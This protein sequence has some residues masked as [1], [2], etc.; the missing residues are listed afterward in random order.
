M[1]CKNDLKIETNRVLEELIPTLCLFMQQYIDSSAKPK[2]QISYIR[3]GDVASPKGTSG[4][5]LPIHIFS[6]TLSSGSGKYKK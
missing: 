5:G 4:S 2:C 3:N 6:C 1:K